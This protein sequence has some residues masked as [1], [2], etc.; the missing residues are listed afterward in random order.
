MWDLSAPRRVAAVDLK[1]VLRLSAA[2]LLMNAALIR[3][4]RSL[5]FLLSY[6]ALNRGRRFI[7]GGAF[8]SKYGSSNFQT[9]TATTLKLQEVANFKKFFHVMQTINCIHVCVMYK[10]KDTPL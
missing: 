8:S 10:N 4:R 3:G 9:F 6:A 7:G 2:L 1:I 5:I